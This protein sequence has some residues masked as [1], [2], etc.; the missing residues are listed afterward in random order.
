[1]YPIDPIF[2][3]NMNDQQRA[4]FYAEYERARKDEVIGVLLALFLGCFGIHH[5]YLRRDGLGILYLLFFW[6]GITTILGFIE[7][8]FM[9]GRV[10]QYNAMQAMYISNQILGTTRPHQVWT[11]GRGRHPQPQQ[12]AATPV[13]TPSIRPPSSAT[14]VEPQSPTPRSAPNLC[15]EHSGVATEDTSNALPTKGTKKR[16]RA[17]RRSPLS[18]SFISP[19]SYRDSPA[20]TH[21][22]GVSPQPRIQQ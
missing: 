19:S 15:H 17:P 1:M 21:L 3:A 20:I 18:F 6:T 9:P 22:R 2:T 12:T 16:K 13:E 11:R 7:C 10:R 14:T 4:W 8:F 5:F